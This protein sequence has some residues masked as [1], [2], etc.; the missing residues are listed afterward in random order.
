MIELQCLATEFKNIITKKTLKDYTLFIL[1]DKC[2][3]KPH[4]S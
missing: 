4:D 2:G 3:L 1:D